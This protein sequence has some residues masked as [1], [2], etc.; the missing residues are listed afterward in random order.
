ML[1]AIWR[2]APSAACVSRWGEY[3]GPP[4]ILPIECYDAVR[5]LQGDMGA[6]SILYD[7]QRP[8]P[9]EV[10]NAR[11]TYDLDCPEDLTDARFV[12]ALDDAEALRCVPSEPNHPSA[13]PRQRLHD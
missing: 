7:A 4:V 12:N 5:Q 2:R 1:H 10:T 6:R 3:A 9:L 13:G 11:A 8:G